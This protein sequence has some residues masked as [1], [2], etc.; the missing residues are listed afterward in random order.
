[1]NNKH[2]KNTV[3]DESIPGCTT[4]TFAPMAKSEVNNSH[5]ESKQDM[6]ETEANGRV[7]PVKRERIYLHSIGRFSKLKKLQMRTY[8][9]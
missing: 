4:A 6:T 3:Y 2:I 9:D 1:M 5:P 8:S 7:N